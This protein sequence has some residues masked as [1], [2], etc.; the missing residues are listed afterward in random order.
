ME[1]DTTTSKEIMADEIQLGYE[2]PMKILIK[3]NYIQI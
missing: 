2:D 3:Q 1:E